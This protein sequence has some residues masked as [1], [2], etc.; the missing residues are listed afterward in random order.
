MNSGFNNLVID[1]FRGV[2]KVHGALG[3]MLKMRPL[4]SFFIDIPL[5]I[6]NRSFNGTQL[7]WSLFIDGIIFQPAIKIRKI[8]C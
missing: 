2:M 5:D 8:K 1:I 4:L 7:K 3:K 6:S